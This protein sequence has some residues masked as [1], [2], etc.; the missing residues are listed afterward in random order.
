MANT[1]ILFVDD[2]ERIL[3]GIARQQDDFDI[4]TA[5]GPVAALEILQEEGPF[6]VVVSDMRMPEMNGLQLLDQVAQRWP[7][8]VRMILTGFSEIEFVI[9]AVNRGKVFRFLSK[10]CDED[11]LAASLQDGLKQ[12]ALADTEREILEETLAGSLKML[13]DVLALSRPESFAHLNRVRAVVD[14]MASQIEIQDLWQVHVAAQLHAI[15]RLPNPVE[16]QESHPADF[17]LLTAQMVQQ[18]P[19]MIAVSEILDALQSPSGNENHAESRK[20]QVLRLAFEFDQQQQRQ[21]SWQAA[22]N[23]IK[24]NSSRFDKDLLEALEDWVVASSCDKV[25]I[26]L[27]DLQVGMILADDLKS[28][29]GA[30]RMTRGQ[31]VSA[32]ALQMIHAATGC[33]PSTIGIATKRNGDDLR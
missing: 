31:T 33:L 13:T 26:A 32:A 5:V 27:G 29:Q 16:V 10:P 6:A 8:T 2:D 19:R 1:K 20:V 23:T 30:L 28:S 11:L 7:S 18:L 25:Q 17:S 24:A 4:T 12:Y 21:N 22:I 9:E 3:K 15:G 14:G